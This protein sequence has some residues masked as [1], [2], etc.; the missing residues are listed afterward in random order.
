VGHLAAA[1]NDGHGTG[2]IS[3]GDAPFDHC[4]DALEAFR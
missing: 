1:R 4:I 2:E 3:G